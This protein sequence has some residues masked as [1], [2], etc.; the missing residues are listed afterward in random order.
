MLDDRIRIY[1][2]IRYSIREQ[3]WVP[4]SRYTG[5]FCILDVL[6]EIYNLLPT[7]TVE[8]PSP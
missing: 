2:P 4:T 8:F 3:C 5:L 7:E 6:E 1:I